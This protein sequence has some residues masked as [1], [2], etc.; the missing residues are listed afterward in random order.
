MTT[1]REVRENVDSKLDKLETKAIAIESQLNETREATL[2]RIESQ[3]LEYR[4]NLKRLKEEVD[5]SKAIAEDKKNELY[6]AIEHAEVQLALGKAEAS[7]AVDRQRKTIS[8]AIA[9]VEAK[10]D[11]GLEQADKKMMSKLV[12][13]ADKLDAEMEAAAIRVEKENIPIDEKLAQ[14]KSDIESN[15][16]AFKREVAAKRKA[17]SEKWEQVEDELDT[18][19]QK[20]T[21]AFKNIFS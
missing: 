1:I 2:S 10:I 20:L 9:E 19:F 7:D 3:K 13:A 11:S 17:A 16:N 8:H 4:E 15:I 14:V 21:E 6:A 18:R 12:T 5:E